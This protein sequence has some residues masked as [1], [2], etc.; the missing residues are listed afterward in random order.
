[1]PPLPGMKAVKELGLD[2]AAIGCLAG[3]PVKVPPVRG[4]TKAAKKIVTVDDVL[5]SAQEKWRNSYRKSISFP[6]HLA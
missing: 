6:F 5:W 4:K 1:M 2:K 3:F